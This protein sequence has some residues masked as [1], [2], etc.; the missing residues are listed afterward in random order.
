LKLK[1]KNDWITK[2]VRNVFSNSELR[3]LNEMKSINETGNYIIGKID[4]SNQQVNVRVV[5][6][7]LTNCYVIISSLLT[8]TR[9]ID[10]ICPWMRHYPQINGPYMVFYVYKQ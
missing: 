9:S 4:S 3:A 1:A 5:I 6:N 10:H 8:L 7:Y 2:A